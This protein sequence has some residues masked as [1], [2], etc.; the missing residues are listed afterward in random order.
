MTS[1]AQARRGPVVVTGAAGVV[2][3]ALVEAFTSG[4]AG[5]GGSG[6][7]ARVVLRLCDLPGAALP[8]TDVVHGDLTDAATAD[9]A[10]VGAAAVV[11][12]AGE[13]RPDAPWD[14]LVRGNLTLTTAVLDAAARQG[15]ARVVLA[16]SVHAV[17]DNGPGAWPVD[18]AD[19]ARPCC[20]YGVTKAAAE[21]LARDHARARPTTSVV[22]LRLGLVADR[23]RWQAEALGWTPLD[24]LGPFVLGALAAPPGYHCV[25]AV[26]TPGT[27]PRYR[28]EPTTRLLGHER[29]VRPADLEGLGDVRPELAAGCRLWRQDDAGPVR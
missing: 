21:L 16:G 8:P 25:H 22:T 17:G 15:V 1:A 5:A 26:A 24:A 13:P 3:R 20:R 28:T 6:P 27:A 7:A 23:P 10:L 19:A 29:R 12:L 9:R 11:H 18:P 14:R 2:G 4:G